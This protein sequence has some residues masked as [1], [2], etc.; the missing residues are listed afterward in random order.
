MSEKILLIEDDEKLTELL[1]LYLTRNGFDVEVGHRGTDAEPMLLRSQPDLLIL[2]L[3]LPGMDG[4]S[5]CRQVRSFFKGKILILTASDD[6]MDQ[7]AALEMGADDFVCKPLQPRVLLARIRMLLRRQGNDSPS[8]AEKTIEKAPVSDENVSLLRLGGLELNNLTQRC[9]LDGE[10]VNITPG[11][12]D[13]LWYLATNADQV[14]SRDQLVKQT[15][16]IEYDGVDRTIDN[17]IVLLRKKLNDNPSLPNRI[18][19]VRGKGYL[20][21]SNNWV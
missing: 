15:R 8:T 3:M 7:V 14:L 20:L 12:F 6:D 4:L 17:K 18:I 11:E 9:F 1:S 10:L 19:T 5:V 13:L 2:D 21:V 16:G